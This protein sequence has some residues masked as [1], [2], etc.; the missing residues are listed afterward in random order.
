MYKAL[1]N[2]MRGLDANFQPRPLSKEQPHPFP[3]T[4]HLLNEGGRGRDSNAGPL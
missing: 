4:M 2:P 1:N 3:V